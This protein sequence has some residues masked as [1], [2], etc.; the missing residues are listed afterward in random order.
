MPNFFMKLLLLWLLPLLSCFPAAGPP[1]VRVTFRPL[2]KAA[3]LATKKMAIS[4]K[5]VMTFPLKKVW[6]RI[7]IPTAEGRVFFKDKL[8]DEGTPERELYYYHGYSP[9]LKCHLIQHDFWEYSGNILLDKSGRQTEVYT[10]PVYSPNFTSFATISAGIA[11]AVFPNEIRMYRLENHHWKQ[12]WI[13]EP[14]VEPA[15]WAPDEIQWLSNTTLLL[16]KKMW[17]GP[18]PGTTFIYSRLDIR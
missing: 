6:G 11:D 17:T 15:T 9:Q 13:L 5:P 3:Y 4:T 10:K 1:A 14:A 2:T 8:A 16:K 18:Y 7:V 12:I